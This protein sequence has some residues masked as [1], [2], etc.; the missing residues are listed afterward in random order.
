M[1]KQTNLTTVREAA[2]H[3]R[4][5]RQAV[6]RALDERRLTEIRIGNVRLVALDRR[7]RAFQARPYGD[8]RQDAA[9]EAHRRYQKR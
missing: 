1:G 4:C 6:Y 5:S 9:Y 7:F 3:F 8:K 2:E